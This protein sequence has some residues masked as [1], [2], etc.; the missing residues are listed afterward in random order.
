MINKESTRYFSNNHELSICKALGGQRVPNSGAGR[1]SAGDVIIDNV[2]MLIEAKCS[3]SKKKSVSIKEDWIL[4][5]KEE[6]FRNRLQ[7]TAICFN[8]EPNGDNYYIIDEKLMR[9]L[10]GALRTADN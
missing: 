5:N 10:I 2:S 1:F 8:F 6:A 7:N 3:M 4:K 9:Y